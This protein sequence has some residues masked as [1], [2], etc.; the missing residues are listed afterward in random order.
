MTS[1]GNEVK[2]FYITDYY[3]NI[4][5]RNWIVNEY[6]KAIGLLK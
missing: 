4:S 5:P 3:N 1:K 2:A 6:E